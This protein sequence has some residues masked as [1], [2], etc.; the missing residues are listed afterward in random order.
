MEPG[1]YVPDTTEGITR[2]ADL[3]APIV[4][5]RS[6]SYRRRRCPCCGQSCY[7]DSLGC[8]I[9]YD[10]GD[11]R[12]GRPRDLLVRYSKH[13]CRHYRLYF[14]ADLCDLAPPG[15]RYT[16]RVISLAVRLAVEDGLPFRLSSWH[17]W[18]DQ[19][20]FVPYATIQNWVEAAG[21][22]GRRAS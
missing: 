22:K 5:R 18:R 6:R 3:P 20:V 7:R 11:L 2:V 14:N 19:R 1:E 16:Q 15:S 4:Q 8:R 13:H 17:L 10:I 9:L 21:K 12:S